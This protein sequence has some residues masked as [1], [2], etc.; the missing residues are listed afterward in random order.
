MDDPVTKKKIK[1][2]PF[3]AAALVVLVIGLVIWIV[4]PSGKKQTTH[5]EQIAL[6]ERY[7]EELDYDKAIA[8]YK[9]AMEIDPDRPEAYKG[10]VDVYLA[11]ADAA[12]DDERALKILDEAMLELDQLQQAG[13]S[14][15]SVE[16][17]RVLV[18]E[19][20]LKYLG[21]EQSAQK[22][23][24]AEVD[25]TEDENVVTPTNSP[26]EVTPTEKAA[27]TEAVSP[28]PEAED[29]VENEKPGSPEEI[30]KLIIDHYQ[31]KYISQVG[32]ITRDGRYRIEGNMMNMTIAIIDSF[33]RTSADVLDVSVNMD[34]GLCTDSWGESANLW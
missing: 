6:A 2:L 26:K 4:I 31:K 7:L 28:T 3:A 14:I 13:N 19:A 25:D 23:E 21:S 15:D 32:V 12:G 27:P 11:K 33:D 10:I 16:E 30:E 29:V 9:K 1:W 20:R 34:T 24:T 17:Y 8:A 5:D 22:E 18:R